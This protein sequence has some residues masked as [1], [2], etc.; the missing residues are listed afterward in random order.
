MTKALKTIFEMFEKSL[1]HF[2]LSC[3]Q[4][5]VVMSEIHNTIR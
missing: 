5:K 2:Y 4:S 1:R 3:H